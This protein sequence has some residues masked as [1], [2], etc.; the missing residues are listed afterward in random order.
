MSWLPFRVED[1]KIWLTFLKETNCVS[2]V[3]L[4][5]VKS[6]CPNSV[7]PFSTLFSADIQHNCPILFCIC[8][9]YFP[10]WL[11]FRFSIKK[12]LHL[13][14]QGKW[15]LSPSSFEQLSFSLRFILQNEWKCQIQSAGLIVQ[16]SN[17]AS[18]WLAE[19]SRLH[20]QLHFIKLQHQLEPLLLCS[21]TSKAPTET[22]P[23]SMLGLEIVLSDAANS[24][25]VSS[26]PWQVKNK[27]VY[28]GSHTSLENPW[29]H[30][31]NF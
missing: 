14:F 28:L 9:P 12:W 11:A 24:A 15:P 31:T 5:L 6:S 21:D 8:R 2:H 18:G 13:H 7:N 29:E 20:S 25:Q 27:V 30:Y 19:L 16:L 17:S 1:H 4:H 23:N 22:V 3:L 10:P 26:N